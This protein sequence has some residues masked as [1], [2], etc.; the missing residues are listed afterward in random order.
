VDG[1]QKAAPEE[2]AE[3]KGITLEM[4]QSIKTQLE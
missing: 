1:I 4:A 3:I 2:I